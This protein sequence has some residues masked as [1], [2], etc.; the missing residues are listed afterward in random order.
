MSGCSKWYTSGN[1]HKF[2]VMHDMEG[3][4]ASTISYLNQCGVTASI[5]YMVNGKHDASSDYPAGEIDQQVREANYAWHARCWNTY[6]FGTEHEGFASSPA[7]Y[8]EPMYQATSALQRH[9]CNDFS[10]TKNRNHIVGHNEWKS[11][12]WRTWAAANLGIDPNCNSHSDPGAYWDWTHLMALVN[13]ENPPYTFASD[14]MG[15]TAGNSMSGITWNG[16]SWPGIIYGDQTGSDAYFYS[17]AT[18]YTGDGA[19]LVNV[20][21]YPQNGTSASHDMQV[22]WKTSDDDTW[23]AGKSSPVVN[24]TAQN[25]WIRLNV[26]VN[27]ADYVGELISQLRLDFDQTSVGTRWLVN[28][29]VPQSSLIWDFASTSQAWIPG[30]GVSAISWTGSSWPGVIYVDQTG[31]DAYIYSTPTYFDLA[32][33]YKYLG[34]ANDRIHVRIYPQNGTTANH[35]M[36]VFWKT[37]GDNTWTASKSSAVVN[38]SAQ[39][40]WADVYLPVGTNPL[41]NSADNV[42]GG[43]T[44][45][46]L[47]FDQVNQGNRWIIDYVHF[48]QN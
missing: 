33:A 3:Y 47:D 15:W 30:S 35:D 4:Y 26:N 16:T 32:S 14:K 36:Q 18:S 17:P 22:F 41:W 31:N 42:S 28:H 21:V 9:L 10:I 12:A 24:Y 1:G 20:S 11:S 43:I 40:A 5:H 44:E 8:T 38:Y 27:Q 29:V 39:N 13:V 34:G 6:S 45:I 37:T 19:G 48:E 7:W 23:T 25:N 2:V 46:R